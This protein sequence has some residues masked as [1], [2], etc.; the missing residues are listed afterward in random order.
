MS[1]ADAKLVEHLDDAT[2]QFDGVK[3]FALVLEYMLV[4]QSFHTGRAA[5]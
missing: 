3:H 5:L 2:A 1:Y 4:N